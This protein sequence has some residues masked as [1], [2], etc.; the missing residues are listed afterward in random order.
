MGTT[1]KTK[2]ELLAYI[3]R[4]RQEAQK[5]KRAAYRKKLKT[6]LAQVQRQKAAISKRVKTQELKGQTESAAR[7]R[8]AFECCAVYEERLKNVLESFDMMDEGRGHGTD[9]SEGAG[10]GQTRM[11]R[12]EAAHG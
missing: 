1:E 8:K 2:Q 5:E 12:T 4:Y 3:D 6:E 9:F 11:Q 10:I 7:S